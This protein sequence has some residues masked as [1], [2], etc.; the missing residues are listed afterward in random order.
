MDEISGSYD[1]CSSSNLQLEPSDEPSEHKPQWL[2]AHEKD[3]TDSTRL[4]PVLGQ[5]QGHD[6]HKTRCSDELV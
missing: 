6:F 3:V 4:P 5:H 1:K 2:C